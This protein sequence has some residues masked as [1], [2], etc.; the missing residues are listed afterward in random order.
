MNL[1]NFFNTI[2]CKYSWG[3]TVYYDVHNGQAV[4][5]N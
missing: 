4:F 3:Y 5:L 2:V 1:I